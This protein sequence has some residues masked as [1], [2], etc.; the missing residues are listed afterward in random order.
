MPP[1]HWFLHCHIDKR[2]DDIGIP[3]PIDVPGSGN[4]IAEQSNGLVSF[5]HR[6]REIETGRGSEIDKCR[7]FSGFSIVIEISADDD[8][9]IPIPLM[10]PAPDTDLPK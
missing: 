7:P 10:S 8:I 1:L 4:G 9:G 3:I 5:Q 2:D 6:G